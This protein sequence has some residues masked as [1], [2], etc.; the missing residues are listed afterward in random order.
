MGKGGWP[1]WYQTAVWEM[2]SIIRF[3]SPYHCWSVM[4]FQRVCLSSATI[5]NVGKRGPFLRGRPLAWA[6]RA[7]RGPHPGE[8]G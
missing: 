3:F 7:H 4:R 1:V 5:S 8:S 2:I 6:G